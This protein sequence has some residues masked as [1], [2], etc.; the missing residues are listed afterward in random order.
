MLEVIS[1]KTTAGVESNFLQYPSKI[2]TVSGT[3]E[4]TYT[5]LPETFLLE[6]EVD[7]P[8]KR[9]TPSLIAQAVAGEYYLVEGFIEKA[10]VFLEKYKNKINA[11]YLK[12]G[13]RLHG[14]RY[15]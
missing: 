14:G 10:Q 9:I 3:V 12:R 6:Q 2:K 5:Y 13:L 11:L 1:V 4:I 8:D 15:L 7:F